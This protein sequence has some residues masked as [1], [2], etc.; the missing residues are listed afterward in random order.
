MFQLLIS[1]ACSCYITKPLTVSERARTAF[2]VPQ[3]DR[4]VRLRC[5]TPTVWP[6]Y[7]TP[8]YWDITT[9]VF[10]WRP[11][12]NT[13]P[14]TCLGFRIPGSI[15]SPCGS[16]SYCGAFQG[17]SEDL[18]W[19]RFHVTSGTFLRKGVYFDVKNTF[20][21]VSCSRGNRLIRNNPVTMLLC[22]PTGISVAF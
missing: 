8:L 11:V 3:M 19:D 21:S 5:Q 14:P 18:E 7:G 20:Y 6:P 10:Q 9:P 1:L 12:R 16:A 15:F 17:I 4:Y 2:W 13:F 22:G